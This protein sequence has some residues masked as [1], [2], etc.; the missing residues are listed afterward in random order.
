[1]E[2]RPTL[3]RTVE[4]LENDYRK[5]LKL[6]AGD[7]LRLVNVGKEKS[8]ELEALMP[9]FETAVA[10]RRAAVDPLNKPA[11]LPYTNYS[12]TIAK[13]ACIENKI[14]YITAP[15]GIAGP[16][17]I[18]GGVTLQAPMA[19][20]EGALVASTNRGCAA[21]M[22]SGGVKTVVGGNDARACLQVE[23]RRRC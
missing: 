23:Q 16:L 20:T 22:R 11:D 15:A 2:V 7:Y 17:K 21:I 19:T 9:D 8:R 14:G 18:N 1:A 3:D 12:Y 4:E 10:V 5:G 13:D 6:R